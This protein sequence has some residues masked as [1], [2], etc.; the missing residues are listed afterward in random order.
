M[1]ERHPLHQQFAFRSGL[2]TG[3]EL[4]NPPLLPYE[5]SLIRAIGCSEDE[6]RELIRHAMLRQRV[7]PAEYDHIP[8]IVNDPVFTPTFFAQLA[9]G[10]ALTAASVLL[11]P[12]NQPQ[13]QAK[14]KGKKLADQIGPT[15]FNQTTNFDN[16]ASLAELNQPIPIPFGSPGTGADSQPTGGLIIA[17]A[18]V[19][20]RLYAYGAFQAYEGIYV[21][22]QFGLA[23]PD[24]GG[25]LLGTSALNALHDKEYAFYFSS[26]KGGNRP[27]ESNI[28]HGKQGP[29]ATGTMGRNIFKTPLIPDNDEG[30]RNFSMAYTPSGDTSFGTSNPIHNGTAYRFN[31][32][33]ISAPFVSTEGSGNATARKQIQR[34]RRKI[35]GTKADQLHTVGSEA[36]QPGVGRSYSRCMGLTTYNGVETQKKQIHTANIGDLTVFEIDEF[37]TDV[38]PQN[39]NIEPVDDK[40]TQKFKELTAD[41]TLGFVGSEIDLSDLINSAKGW[42]EKT[43]DLLVV[44]SRWMINGSVWVVNNV[45]KGRKGRLKIT[46]ECVEIFGNRDIGVAGTDAVRKSLSGYEGGAFDKDVHCDEAHYNICKVNIASIRPV[47]R[48]ARVIELGIQSQ[49]FNKASGLCNFN[50]VPSPDRLFKLDKDDV[51]LNTP[52]MDKF[53]KR[54]SCF[55]IYVRRVKE[56]N[57]PEENY[58]RIPVLLCVQGSAP[59]TQNNFIRIKPQDNGYYEYKIVPRSGTDVALNSRRNAEVIIL[60]AAEG[61]PYAEKNNLEEI[62]ISRETAFGKFELTTQGREAFVKDIR[63]SAEMVTNP[64]KTGN[65]I[66]VKK[67][68][69]I[70]LIQKRTNKGGGF[71]KQVAFLHELLGDVRGPDT[72]NGQLVSSDDITISVDANRTITVQISARIRITFPGD[73][74]FNDRYFRANATTDDDLNSAL[75]YKELDFKVIR[76]TGEFSKDD[77]FTITADIGKSNPYRQFVAENDPGREYTQVYFDMIVTEIS[78][79]PD[80][81]LRTADRVFEEFTQCAD[82]SYYQELTKSNESG[83]EHKIVYVNEYVGNQ[84]LAIYDDMSTIG[85]T[86]KSSGQ[87]AEVSQMRL[88]SASGIPVERLIEGDTAPSNLL[89]DLVFYLL[90]NESQGVGKVVPSEL[91]DKDS[92]RTTARFLRANRIFF[93]GVLEDSESFRSFLYD[94]APLQL[95]TF[96]IKNGRFGMMPALPFNSNHEISLDPVDVRQIFTAGN[97]IEDTLQLQYIDVAQRSDIRALV[98]WRV[99]RGNDLPYQATALVEF[100][101]T[102]GPKTE[103]AFDLSE[104]CT[105]RSQAL[106]TAQFLLSTRRR[107]SKTVSFKTVPDAL[108]VEP[109]SYIRVITEAATYNSAANG[110]ITDAGTLQSIKYITNG[111][112]DALVYKPATQEVI[113]TKLEVANNAITDSNFY[114]SLFTLLEQNTDFSVYQIEQLTLD[115]DGLVSI[116]AVEVPTNDSGV[117]LVVQDVLTES[118]FKITE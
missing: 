41:Q 79:I 50:A 106:R 110:A 3:G 83:P 24:L 27:K 54:S 107:V 39:I 31:W 60:D 37:A 7:R 82:L 26:N 90:T 23:T 112:Y 75:I 108:S 62:T 40:I 87:I 44:G 102:E 96:T 85:F 42:T 21:A 30:I 100:K 45:T 116:S 72:G 2:E 65:I 38:V 117:S 28:L 5:K 69:A 22:G 46:L 59:V 15:R 4:F 29:G 67:P 74:D 1:A 66:E 64:A 49:V 76:S 93:D 36:G 58:D 17:P 89:A 92:L 103:Q 95:C 57:Q 80:E 99:T 68:E 20:S 14:V 56:N 34:N 63:Q 16:V 88:R 61:T 32:E 84:D 118:N 25:I 73:D 98:T 11:A 18:L 55:S 47:R 53:F 8:H 114:G 12:K 48:D 19:W 86:V 105:N 43:A 13:D 94:N 109:G 77:R 35:A 81:Q 115:E 111:T 91:V 78:K 70:N 6:Y 9:I 97:I 10:V 113:E 104:F 51:Q 52:R 71:L 101:D 33:V